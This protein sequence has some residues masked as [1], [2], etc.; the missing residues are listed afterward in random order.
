MCVCFWVWFPSVI[1]QQTLVGLILISPTNERDKN[2]GTTAF[3]LYMLQGVPVTPCKTPTFPA[4]SVLVTGWRLFTLQLKGYSAMVEVLLYEVNSSY[5]PHRRAGLFT[6]TIA[7][8]NS[9]FFILI[10]FMCRHT[11]YTE[12][13]NKYLQRN[14][15]RK[16][17]QFKPWTQFKMY[18]SWSKTEF[19]SLFLLTSLPR[20]HWCSRNILQRLMFSCW[21]L[22]PLHRK[23]LPIMIMIF[24]Q[25]FSLPFSLKVKCC[26][27]IFIHHTL[28]GTDFGIIFSK[29]LLRIAPILI[30]QSPCNCDWQ[31]PYATP[32]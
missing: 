11:T 31:A 10:L 18:Y 15:R 19:C 14:G 4:S 6:A 23:A 5:F 22:G 3:G 20:T 26:E 17:Q 13:I 12:C 32:L 8:H 28:K 1:W 21:P 25:V 29:S 16:I 7:P 2:R 24:V 30:S 9:A 27:Y